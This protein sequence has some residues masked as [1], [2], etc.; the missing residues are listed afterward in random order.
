MRRGRVSHNP[1]ENIM[2]RS[3][4][5]IAVLLASTSPVF[6]HHGPGSF[7]LTKR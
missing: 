2:K 1:R 5:L 4:A 7:D 6:A 3:A